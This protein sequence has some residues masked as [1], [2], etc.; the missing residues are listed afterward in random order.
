MKPGG[1]RAGGRAPPA[2]PPL[3]DFELSGF[4]ALAPALSGNGSVTTVRL[5][6]GRVGRLRLPPLRGSGI[7]AA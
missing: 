3:T 5:G 1:G 6:T 7:A 4:D 2:R